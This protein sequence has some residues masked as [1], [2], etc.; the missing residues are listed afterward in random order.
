MTTQKSPTVL[1]MNQ[2]AEKDVIVATNSDSKK[3]MSLPQHM[4][5]TTI[6]QHCPSAHTKMPSGSTKLVCLSN[7]TKQNGSR[8]TSRNARATKSA[9]SWRAN[10][11]SMSK[12]IA[13]AF[14][15]KERPSQYEF[16]KF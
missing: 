12:T 9:D 11:I 1:K 2:K 14:I 4:D 6:A 13:A 15:A 10:K 5:L 16:D 3:H 7:Q 8:P